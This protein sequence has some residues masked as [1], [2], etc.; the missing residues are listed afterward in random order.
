MAR[1]FD[2]VDDYL[3]APSTA[4]LRSPS[5]AL[6]ISYWAK[7]ATSSATFGRVLQKSGANGAQYEVF[8]DTTPGKHKLNLDFGTTVNLSTATVT[9]DT[10][11]WLFYVWRWNSGG[12][13]RV[14]IFDLDG[15]LVA[16][17]TTATNTGTLQTSTDSTSTLWVM[18]SS[19]GNYMPG[20]MAR[21]FIHN[22]RLTDAEVTTLRGGQL[23]VAPSAD[24]WPL[25]GTG[26]T[27]VGQTNGNVLTVFGALPASDSGL[28]G[29]LQLLVLGG[30]LTVA[31]AGV[32]LTQQAREG[33]VA[34][35]GALGQTRLVARDA[36]GA[37]SAAGQA[38]RQALASRAG[39]V[40]TAG[41]L[42]KAPSL[43]E[44]GSVVGA[45]SVARSA[46]RVLSGS[47]QPAAARVQSYL[48][49]VFGQAGT[50]VLRA[51]AKATVRLRARRPN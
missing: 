33:V 51:Y 27:E 26:A 15:A 22:A 17:G 29:S 3:T 25:D 8:Q 9:P 10:G 49:R 12:G 46:R 35:T 48:G 21:L 34:A 32:G 43:L 28:P 18:R 13:S 36:L 6:T 2:G 1:S 40:A 7:V 14:D 23:P 38:A 30:A 16:S 24:Y 41:A 50:V 44:T 31:G 4:Q 20:T 5:T 45:G 11:I 19:G 42:S 37:I 47:M 39:T